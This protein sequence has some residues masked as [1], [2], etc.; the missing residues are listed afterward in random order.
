MQI[1][2]LNQILLFVVISVLTTVLTIAGIQ[3][4]HILK[5]FRESVRMLNKILEDTHIVSSSVAKPMAGISSFLTGLKS[6][7][8]VINMF[9][10]S[11][12]KKETNE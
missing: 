3:V 11:K 4:I 8:D 12:K 1:P 5:E 10:G 2:Y 6:G 7:A 9:L